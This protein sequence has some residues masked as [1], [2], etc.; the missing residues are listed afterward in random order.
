MS[1]ASDRAGLARARRMARAVVEHHFGKTAK[2]LTHRSGGLSNFVFEADHAEGEF[3][4]RI[5]NDAGKIHAYIK[6]Q[7]AIGRVRALGVPTPEVL[8]VGS[9]VVAAPYMIARRLRG[10]EA[11]HH[12]ARLEILREM[13]HYTRLINTVPTTGYGRSFDWS[14]NQLSHNATW[15][16]FLADELRLDARIDVLRRHRMLRPDQLRRVRN[17]LQAIG[18]KRRRPTLNHGDMRLKNVVVDDAGKILAIIDWEECCSQIAPYW[19]LSLALH[20]LSIDAKQVFLE[21]YGVSQKEIVAMAPTLRAL[22]L[23]NYVPQI[24]RMAANRERDRLDQYRT[25]LSGALDLYA[26]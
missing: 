23:I 7:W 1:R 15:Q 10:N 3:I 13:G 19:D 6:E 24:E 12:P 18:R 9:D 14:A 25:R 2:R 20:D 11:T 26:L 22:N 17:L 16:A 5:G 4:I 21:G 8:E